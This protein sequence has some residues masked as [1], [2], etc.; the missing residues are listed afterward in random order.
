[1]VILEKF[2]QNHKLKINQTEGLTPQYGRQFVVQVNSVQTQKIPLARESG[3][4]IKKTI[5][6]KSP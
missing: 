4:A 6:G 5:Y 2:T 3:L 1:M